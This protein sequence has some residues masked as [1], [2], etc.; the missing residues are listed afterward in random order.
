M[1]NVEDV[2]EPNTPRISPTTASHFAGIDDSTI[3]MSFGDIIS[4]AFEVQ[5]AKMEK[6]MKSRLMEDI[7]AE[8]EQKVEAEMMELRQMV[9]S[10]KIEVEQLKGSKVEQLKESNAGDA[11]RDMPAHFDNATKSCMDITTT[12]PN[13]LNTKPSMP[14]ASLLKQ[15]TA[16]TIGDSQ[17]PFFQ[18]KPANCVFPEVQSAAE[19]KPTFPGTTGSSSSSTPVFP[20]MSPMKEIS[21]L[22][23]S[24]MTRS[25]SRRRAGAVPQGK[26]PV[27]SLSTPHHLPPGTPSQSSR[28]M[29][30]HLLS[31]PSLQRSLTAPPASP[32]SKKILT[33]DPITIPLY[34]CFFVTASHVGINVVVKRSPGQG[35]KLWIFKA[36]RVG[37]FSVEEQARL[38]WLKNTNG[39][40]EENMLFKSPIRSLPSGQ[41]GFVKIPALTD[42][43][44]WV[45]LAPTDTLTKVFGEHPVNEHTLI[46]FSIKPN[47][48]AEIVVGFVGGYRGYLSKNEY[49]PQAELEGM[50]LAVE[51]AAS[52]KQDEKENCAETETTTST[53]S[54]PTAVG[55]PFGIKPT[56]D[57]I[58]KLKEFEAK[59]YFIYILKPNT[60]ESGRM[61]Y[62]NLQKARAYALK[63]LKD[64]G[65]I[66]EE[67]LEEERKYQAVKAAKDRARARPPKPEDSVIPAIIPAER[68]FLPNLGSSC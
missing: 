61:I 19:Q 44:Y 52:I 65:E 2:S 32:A 64:K 57:V 67:E 4:K 54:S 42:D 49:C 51:F 20:G 3:T 30:T 41:R 23:H 58:G 48:I 1:I 14:P 26:E 33:T 16:P 40:M 13:P 12:P 53:V 21:N 43:V 37:S 25:A 50:K 66:L 62:E 45:T 27:D 35:A 8:V 38:G 18:I 7:K 46:K 24:M 31:T 5:W 59:G 9:E 47:N 63:G 17:N 22:D 39:L 56:D 68:P 28:S 11:F 34:P 6:M 36:R 55:D 10:L 29:Q 60:V 15:M